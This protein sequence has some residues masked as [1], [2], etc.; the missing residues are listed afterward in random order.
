MKNFLLFI[1]VSAGFLLNSCTNGQ[2][3][4]SKTSLTPVEFSGKIEMLA[5]APIID[6][7]TPG[8]FGEGH[9]VNAINIDWN[10]TDFDK[11]ISQFDKSRPVLVYCLSG[12]RSASAAKKMRSDGFSEVYELKGGIMKWRSAGLPETTKIATGSAGMNRQDFDGLLAT[13]KIVLVDFFAEWC[14]PCKKMKPYLDEI[15]KE[16]ADRVVVFRIDVDK[17]PG[18]CREL[19]IDALP[20]LQVYRKKELVWSNTGYIEKE[21]V[22]SH[23]Q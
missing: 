1:T 18:L 3:Q 22:L 6:V 16:M 23:L 2:T 17:N 15:S 19:K 20:V 21:G 7:R 12:S 5:S 9:L 8:E 13:D 4:D 11:Q 10:G 14:L